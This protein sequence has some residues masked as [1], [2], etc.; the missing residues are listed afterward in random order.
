MGIRQ[1]LRVALATVLVIVPGSYVLWQWR[2]VDEPF[3]ED[4]SYEGVDE[5]LSSANDPAF[6]TYA[7]WVLGVFAVFTLAVKLV[8][9]LLEKV[10]PARAPNA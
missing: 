2:H 9:W 5:T 6:W 3:L 1:N 7:L 4:L 8:D 10:F